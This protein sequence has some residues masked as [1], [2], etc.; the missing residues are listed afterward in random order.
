MDFHDALNHIEALTSLTPKSAARLFDINEQG[1][2]EGNT[3]LHSACLSGRTDIVKALLKLGAKRHIMNSMGRTPRDLAGTRRHHI[4]AP[5]INL[6]DTPEAGGLEEEIV[7]EP[8]LL[9]SY[10]P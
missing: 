10:P 5:I 1:D 8:G 7:V 4:S 3:A 2:K 6:L 9:T